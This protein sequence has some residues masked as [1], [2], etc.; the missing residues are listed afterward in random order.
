MERRSV[1]A[2]RE[3]DELKKAE[4]MEDK[5]GENMMALSVL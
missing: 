3:T 5:I 4:Y 2:E 1:D